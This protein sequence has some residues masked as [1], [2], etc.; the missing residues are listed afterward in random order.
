M[1]NTTLSISIIGFFTGSGRFLKSVIVNH[2]L[3]VTSFFLTSIIQTLY[4]EYPD[5][6]YVENFDKKG[7]QGWERDNSQAILSW[8]KPDNH[9]FNCGIYF[10]NKCY[11]TKLNIKTDM[12]QLCKQ[13]SHH[14]AQF[15]TF[16]H[17]H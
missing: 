14:F 9:K 4:K 7:D 12:S 17:S 13:L 1:T 15:I 2:S 6:M 3:S 16:V 5:E 10:V 8:L 11:T